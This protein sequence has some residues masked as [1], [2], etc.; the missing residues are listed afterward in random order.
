MLQTSVDVRLRALSQTWL[1]SKWLDDEKGSKY[2]MLIAVINDIKSGNFTA[3]PNFCAAMTQNDKGL[4]YKG[5][6]VQKMLK[7]GYAW[8]E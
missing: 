6:Q 8:I 4:T 3:T 7:N 5:P 1:Q 2:K